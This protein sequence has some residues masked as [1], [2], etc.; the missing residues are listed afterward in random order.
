MD[1]RYRAACRSEDP[2]LFFPVGKTGPYIEQIAD[3]KAMCRRCPVSTECLSWALASGQ[4]SGVWGGMDEDER[5]LLKRRN[6]RTRARTG[7]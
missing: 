2:E 7:G 5:R 3:A 4:D 6:A 1:W